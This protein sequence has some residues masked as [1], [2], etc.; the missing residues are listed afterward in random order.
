MKRF[1]IIAARARLG[2]RWESFKVNQGLPDKVSALR[3][4]SSRAGARTIS[5]SLGKPFEDMPKSLREL[6]ADILQNPQ[7][8]MDY[9]ENAGFSGVRALLENH[10]ELPS[11]STL[12][13]HGA[14]EAIFA[15]LLTLLNPGDEVLVP[16]PG[17]L[18]YAPMVR[19]LHGKPVEYRLAKAG[20]GFAYELERIRAKVTKKTKAIFLNAPANPT[21]SVVSAHFVRELA[22][23]FPKLKIISDEVYGELSYEEPYIPFAR[24]APNIVSA[25][26]FSKSHALTGWRIGWLGCTDRAF[27]ARILVAHQYI[28]TC[29]NAPAQHL[30]GAL[31]A[32]APLFAAIRDHY[33]AAYLRRRDTIFRALG[34]A[35]EKLDRPA[36]GFYL[37]LPI[38]NRFSSSL[39]F[40][41]T[42]LAEKDVLVTP[43]EFFGS[44]G[45]RHVR[46]S[47][48]TSL[49]NCRKAGEAIRSYY[50]G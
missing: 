36:G 44:L 19:S 28:A 10:Y 8:P 49:E 45:K 1:H 29:A 17:F 50:E 3:A 32:Q 42:L 33:A 13:M 46:I 30:V 24:Y 31:L 27:V 11:G 39:E 22:A 40:G 14:Q 26:A 2:M 21:G 9:S 4:F 47:Y 16:N 18:A 37:F 38:P 5:L 48:A 25:N 35:A 15:V 6:A 23:E 41:E 20:A 43:G 7:L 34:A 12:L